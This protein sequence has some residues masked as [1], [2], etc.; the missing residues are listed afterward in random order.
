[1]DSELNEQ[2]I[3]DLSDK[4]VQARAGDLSI[5]GLLSLIDALAPFSD[6]L[7]RAQ[8]RREDGV[9]QLSS[10]QTA[11]L[12]A[13][14][15]IKP[16]DVMKVLAE[17]MGRALKPGG[18]GFSARERHQ[19]LQFCEAQLR[20]A[21]R[22]TSSKGEQRCKQLRE[23]RSELEA[24]QVVGEPASIRQFEIKVKKAHTDFKG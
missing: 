16:S 3:H 24:C 5:Y 8:R 23:K 15:H 6:E 14:A 20:A 12:E 18:S 10:L 13:E 22:D 21:A 11:V 4:V 9:G 1:M 2:K 7:E 17:E 19:A